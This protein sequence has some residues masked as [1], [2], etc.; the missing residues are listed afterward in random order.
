M[1][2]PAIFRLR[3]RS[4]FS[5]PQVEQELDEELRYHLE[6]QIDEEIARGLT[7]E[8]ARS[9][10]LRS[11][12]GFEQRKEECRDMRGLNL[13]DNLAQ[14]VRFAVR[15]LRKNPGF[16]VTAALMLALGT[17]ASVAIFAFVDAALIKPLPYRDPARLVGVFEEIQ[18]CPRCP[19]SYPDYVD[20]KRLNNVFTSLDAFEADGLMLR[21]ATGSEQVHGAQTT[22]GFFRTLGVSPVLGRDFYANEDQPEAARAVILSYGA[23]Q[24]RY[25]GRPDV[26]GQTVTLNEVP[27]VIVGVLPRDFHF[28]PAG[29]AE[30]WVA[31]HVSNNGCYQ[32]RGCHSL[33]GVGR[34]KDGAGV[35]AAAANMKQIAQELEKQYPDSNRGQG[36]NVF[37]LT[38][39]IVGNVRALMIVLL[40]GAGLLL[41]IASVNVS[42][43]LLV[44]CESRRREIAVRS[45]L[46]ASAGRLIRQFVTEGLV[47]AVTGSALGLV[48]AHWTMQLLT[49]L[50]PADMLGHMPYL[51]GLGWNLR[52]WAFAGAV[53]LISAALFS[54]TPALRLS[55]SDLRAGL[56]EASR[57]SAGMTWRRLGSN[58]VV[59][60]LATAVVLLAGAGLLSKSL[61]RLLQIDLGM[62][63]DHLATLR[64]AV[65]HATYPKPEQVVAIE[66]KVRSSI[67]NLPGVQSVA[68]SSTLP[69]VGGN[70]MW[71]RVV[72]RPFH[73]EHNEVTYREV[74]STYF[75][76]LRARLRRGRF[77]SEDED[78][79]KPPV[80]VIGRSLAEKYFPGEEAVGKQI[81][82]GPPP[83]KPMEIIGIV[84]DIKE[85]PLDETTWPAIY[86]AF[87]QDP[88]RNFSIVVRTSQAE[89]AM[90]PTLAS[91]IRQ[92]DPS[93]S[94]FWPTSMSDWINNSPA[95]YLRRSAASLVGGFAVLALLLGVAGLYGVIAYSVSQRTR[96][97]GVR[98]ALGAHPAD[99]RQLILKEAGWLI[100]AGIVIGLGCSIAA[101]KLMR[102]LLFG[103]AAWDAPTLGAVALVLGVAALLGSYIPARRAASV[104]PVDALRAE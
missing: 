81:A 39:V 11:I 10:A 79:S 58:L 78:A 25:G 50:I 54:L 80:V 8:E 100:G 90:L 37:A 21:T 68:V 19:L 102:G 77:F 34:L 32:R 2:L 35:E 16:I 94:T 28:A 72:G 6:R 41:L 74:S 103:A 45:G 59:L 89:Q 56:T 95:A 3:L 60:E 46:G 57:G 43:L 5:R 7:R 76:T 69:L 9:A 27:N 20:R 29:T 49:K 14:D 87:N 4:L 65:P 71:I 104:N 47:L 63:P 101:A 30:F 83:A 38:E 75:A 23:W 91:T 48:G 85:G 55:F 64:M 51:Q 61:Y 53:S 98:I 96:E 18:L 84:D 99:V 52:V 33:T 62:Q 42:S 36:S 24:T 13:I 67:A 86:V 97:I 12:E 66:H 31:F 44:R 1:R 92:I 26:L 15:Q 22:A 70:T 88:A 82:Y 73:G 40:S 93:I 17:C